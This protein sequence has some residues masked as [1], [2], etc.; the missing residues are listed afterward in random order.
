MDRY[1]K[2]VLTVIA[3]SLLWIGI[4]DFTFISDAMAASGS[5]EGKV[6][7]ID[8]NRYRPIPVEGKGEIT[9]RQK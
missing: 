1:T 2:T 6:V 5:I 4:K 7:E 3:A 9:C 8:F